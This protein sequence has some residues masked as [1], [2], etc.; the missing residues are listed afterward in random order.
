M[1]L[2]RLIPPAHVHAA[3]ALESLRLV[4]HYAWLIRYRTMFANRIHAHL[5]QSGIQLPRER[6]LQPRGREE[7][8][9]LAPRLTPEQQR[10][11]RSH[12][13]MVKGVNELLRGVRQ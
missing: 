12:L 3:A 9:A 2:T 7:L 5:H 10:L 1:L 11:I 13:V 4:R 8:K 6:L